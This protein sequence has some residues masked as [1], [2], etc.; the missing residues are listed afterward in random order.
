MSELSKRATVHFDPVLH[1]ALRIKAADTQ[2]SL[3]E[4]V[5]EAVRVALQEDAEDLAAFEERVAESTI[6]YEALLKD[7]E[8]NGRL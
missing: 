5:N 3:S 2:R 8:A 6:S 1:H 7:L 4:V